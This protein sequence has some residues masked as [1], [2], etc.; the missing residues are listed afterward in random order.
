MRTLA[1][2]P[3]FAPPAA[4]VVVVVSSVT[5]P[6]FE[7]IAET[8]LT[9]RVISLPSSSPPTSKRLVVVVTAYG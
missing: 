7:S 5:M 6:E 4:S 8:D 2:E 3:A 1:E 9:V